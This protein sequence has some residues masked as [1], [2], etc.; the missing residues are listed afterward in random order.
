MA[1]RSA[2]VPVN[3]QLYTLDQSLSN[4][5]LVRQLTVEQ[6][7]RDP[8]A[9]RHKTAAKL[10]LAS[11]TAQDFKL[12]VLVVKSSL[13]APVDS[14]ATR[15]AYADLFVG[16]CQELAAA[17]LAMTPMAKAAVVN[18]LRMH[19]AQA[20]DSGRLAYGAA[21][22]WMEPWYAHAVSQCHSQ[23]AASSPAAVELLHDSSK[24]K[25]ELLR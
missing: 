23:S 25:P 3:W 18:I 11:R 20:A 10:L 14:P 5:H 15:A 21:G 9:S 19:W 22:G 8:D 4:E 2:A 6:E 24:L 7:A 12:P 13:P 16:L 1:T 17:E